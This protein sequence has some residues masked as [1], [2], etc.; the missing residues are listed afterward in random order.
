[1]SRVEEA[2]G[3]GVMP[4][5]EPC[6][7]VESSI[8]TAWPRMRNLLREAAVLFHDHPMPLEA[9]LSI[10]QWLAQ[11]S[12]RPDPL[13]EEFRMLR[14]RPAGLR[15]PELRPLI[16]ENMLN[17]WALCAE[18]IDYLMT[19]IEKMRPA[20][21]LE[22]GSGTST[23]ALAW[24]MR[25]LHGTSPETRVFSID[26]S[27]VYIE[28]TQQRLG[29][30]GLADTVRFLH[31]DLSVQTICSLETRC[32]RL[33]PAVL[34]EWFGA[35]R[36]GLV[37]IDGPAGENGA[38]FGTLPLVRDY[39]APEASIF[40]DDGFRDSELESADQWSRMGYVR[41]DGVRWEGKGLLCGSVCSPATP[42]AERWLAQVQRE[43]SGERSEPVS[44]RSAQGQ[45]F[46][47]DGS[48][49][50]AANR[51]VAVVSAPSSAV[52]PCANRTASKNCVF[53]NT[54]YP[55]FLERHYAVCGGLDQASYEEQ[56]R[57]LQAAC[58]GDS[59][60]YSTGLRQ[61][62]WN[63]ADIIAN[64]A[65]LQRRWA[66]EHG[67]DPTSA[68]G[69][70]LLAQLRDAGA[71]VLYMQDLGMATKEFI[72]AVRPHVDLLVGQIA[73]PIPTQAHL[74]GFD[75][76]I[77]S[78]PHF[79][80]QFRRE[81][82]TAYYQP[83]AFDPRVLQQ[84]GQPAR[85]FPLT[86]V[87]GLSPAH[88]ERQQLLTKLST[89]LP[90]QCWGYGTMAL[91][92]YGIG[93]ERLHGD[94]WGL[95]MFAVLARSSMTV[96]HHIDVAKSNANNMRL[97]EAT[98]CG[99]LLVTDYKDNLA[100]LFEIGSEVVAYRSI[101]E[102][103][104]LLA[105]Y[106]HHPE[107]GAAIAKRGQARTLREHT[108]G[109][110]MEQTAE[111]LARH[112]D[113]KA[114]RNRLPDPDLGRVSYA[115]RQIASHEVTAELAQS[116]CSDEIPRK[117]RAL[118]QRELSDLYRGRSPKVFQVLADALEPHVRPGIGLL[119]VGCASGYYYEALEYLLK[120]RLSYVGVDF[121]PGM[122]RLARTY[123]PQA[124]FEVGDGAALRFEDNAY[125]IVVSSGVL[126]HVQN[127]AAHIAEAARVASGF[128]VLHRT[129]MY[130]TAATA[131]FKKLAYGVET[132]ELRFNEGE[133][134]E[135]CAHA[136]LE[137]EARVEYD[138]Q[139]GRDEFDATY[140]FRKASHAA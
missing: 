129:P 76:L 66:E 6:A 21:V 22:F 138:R 140:V 88:R 42:A 33:P 18:T 128:V 131:Y 23:V 49:Q 9:C 48:S 108:Y 105:Y 4:N 104:D 89:A 84:V 64:C 29:Q 41:W 25:R 85:E 135:L 16:G 20:A 91:A 37:V 132:F 14:V 12:T 44:R 119:E 69:D 106:F 116:W 15:T 10:R 100:D 98:G 59:D 56:H 52:T 17:E 99:A 139:D 123:Y 79:V 32:Y 127:Y 68:S 51:Q 117:Q 97:F 101:E 62:G 61:A 115:H 92:R 118:V 8:E 31:A 75:L 134:F 36:P 111:L 34:T 71:Q 63:A 96:N 27:A 93:A 102:C 124:K 24:A 137:C 28:Q 50:I 77:S 122:I 3:V 110:R 45:A 136:G 125:P 133:L 65:P 11:R 83:L 109:A 47:E 46:A 43:I 38:R 53:L 80:D 2:N 35:A 103:Q 86:F 73:S 130:R 55:G 126:L 60:F 74:D 58:F 67:L 107:E 39:L 114:G 19:I 120:T 94:I 54:Y 121:S 7:T 113:L 81:G 57:S 40:L 1:M 78:F 95:E 30:L 72:A 70:I 90:L 5:V 87:G 13:A 82:R 112:W 26:Q